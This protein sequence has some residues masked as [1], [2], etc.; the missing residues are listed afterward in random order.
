MQQRQT[1]LRPHALR[2]EFMHVAFLQPVHIQTHTATISPGD[3][4][5][6]HRLGVIDFRAAIGRLLDVGVRRHLPGGDFR[7]RLGVHVMGK[8]Q[9]KAIGLQ[10][11]LVNFKRHFARPVN[12]FDGKRLASA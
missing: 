10:P 3:R 8:R 11:H 12:T 4:F 5:G 1:G 7:H 9:L 6:D 2:V